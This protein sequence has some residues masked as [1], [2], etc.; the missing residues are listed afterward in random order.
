MTDLLKLR[1]LLTL[2]ACFATAMS[3]SIRSTAPDQD[4]SA[5]ASNT[6]EVVFRHYL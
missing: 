6:S 1:W 2:F 5:Q 4:A 3:A